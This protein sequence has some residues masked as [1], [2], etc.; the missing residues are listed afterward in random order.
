MIHHEVTLRRSVA[1]GVLLAVAMFGFIWL[2]ST[3]SASLSEYKKTAD[4]FESEC[5]GQWVVT[6]GSQ[7]AFTTNGSD[8]TVDWINYLGRK[9]DSSFWLLEQ[10]KHKKSELY[11]KV[12]GSW[13]LH[14]AVLVDYTWRDTGARC[15]DLE[16]RIGNVNVTLTGGG[17][18]LDYNEYFYFAGTDIGW[19]APPHEH[20]L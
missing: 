20:I 2:S 14:S 9:P 13:V 7:V 6:H 4:V 16:S 12:S 5:A 19:T 8:K 3:A 15:A 18:V 11:E 10:W 17:M 1:L